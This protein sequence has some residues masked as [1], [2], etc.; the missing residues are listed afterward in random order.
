MVRVH[1]GSNGRVGFGVSPSRVSGGKACSPLRPTE[2]FLDEVPAKA[3]SV[4]LRC[5]RR[6]AVRRCAGPGRLPAGAG[7][8]G[9]NCAAGY[10]ADPELGQ[11]LADGE[12]GDTH[13]RRRTRLPGRIGTCVGYLAN[14]PYGAGHP[15]R[16]ASPR[17]AP[18][19]RRT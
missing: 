2:K 11:L 14:N 15:A 10:M 16:F 12:Q 6:R 17:P 8:P 1:P 19:M 7:F 13:G 18:P 4:L 9:Q 3:S 5:Y